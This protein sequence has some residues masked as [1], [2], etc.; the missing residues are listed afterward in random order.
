MNLQYRYFLTTSLPRLLSLQL[1]KPSDSPLHPLQPV[2]L[3]Y[4]H[5]LRKYLDRPLPQLRM[6][7][8]PSSQ[9][10]S[11]SLL[12]IS[13]LTAHIPQLLPAVFCLLLRIGMDAFSG[14]I[15]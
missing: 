13:Q 10:T 15:E 6:Q 1:H 9:L 7:F 11:H 8:L 12:R 14:L 2:L 4:N 5:L 3:P